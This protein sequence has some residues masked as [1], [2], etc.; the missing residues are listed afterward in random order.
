[1]HR[2]VAG[3]ELGVDDLFLGLATGCA[4]VVSSARFRASR[5]TRSLVSLGGHAVGS[6][7]QFLAQLLDAVV[8]VG[9][10]GGPQV[11]DQLTDLGLLGVRHLVAQIGQLPLHAVAQVVGVVLGLAGAFVFSRLLETQLF[12]VTAHDPV[13]FTVV[14]VLL[15]AAAIAGCLIPARR[16]TRIDPMTALRTQ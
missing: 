4:A 14:P 16:A 5:R 2:L 7:L 1:M 10:D 3:A 11:V 12:G 8:V 13:T 6:L 15:I 9:L